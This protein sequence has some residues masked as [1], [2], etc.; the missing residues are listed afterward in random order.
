MAR[1]K[2]EPAIKEIIDH[3]QKYEG[4]PTFSRELELSIG[5]AIY[6]AYNYGVN[7]GR[8]LKGGDAERC[9]HGP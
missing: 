8:F 6:W 4:K 1:V 3:L 9:D 5:P 7:N 2:L